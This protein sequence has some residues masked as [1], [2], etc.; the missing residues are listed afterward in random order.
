ME[1]VDTHC[2]LTSLTHGTTAEI[3]TRAKDAFVTRCITIGASDGL[4][5]AADAL[6]LAQANTNVWCSIG[7]HPHDAGKTTDIESLA[8][9][10]HEPKVVAI[11]ETGL[12]FFRD[13]APEDKQH[14]LFERT[15]A[16]AKLHKK[17]LIIHSRAAGEQC[18]ETLTRLQARDVGG[19]FH[20]YGEDAEFAKRLADINFLV[21]FPGALTF[22]SAHA[23]REIAKAIPLEQI[24]L[25]T[26]APYMA[27]EP[28]R[29]KPSEPAH[30]LQIAQV[31]AK[32]KD[33]S[34]QEVA[35]VTT[36]TARRFYNLQD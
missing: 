9:I 20:C 34:L 27:P 21:S 6:A 35:R 19:V 30:V 4:K 13:W 26:D 36:A 31:M 2:H 10:V 25:E 14:D 22:K 3:L 11:G 18:L 29:G 32:A 28:F 8:A 15:I 23:V 7:I 5:S 24:M 1:L 33:L 16:F 12:D 17:P